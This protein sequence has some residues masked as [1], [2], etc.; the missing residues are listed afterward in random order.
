MAEVAS[1]GRSFHV[2]GPTT[3]KA[4]LATAVNLTGGLS[5]KRNPRPIMAT[6]PKF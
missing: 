5:E 2:H 1:S 3:G 6:T 4:Q